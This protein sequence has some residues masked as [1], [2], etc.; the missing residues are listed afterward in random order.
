MKLQSLLEVISPLC[1]VGSTDKEIHAIHFD[2]RKIEDGDLFVAQAGTAVDGH[3]FIAQCAEKGAAAIVLSNRE[4]MPKVQ[5]D[6]VQSTKELT[7]ILVEDTDR[8]LGLLADCWFGSPSGKLTLVGVTGTNGKTT[9]ATLLY[10]LVR[11]LG[12]K[13]GLLST[14][15]NYVEEE[16]VPATHTT[17][18]ALELNALLARMVSVGCE[19]AFMEVSSHAIAQQR[20]AGLQFDGGLFTNLTR[21]H[22]DYHKTFDNYRDTKKRFFDELPKTAFAVTNIDDKNGTVMTQNTRAHVT[23]YSVRSLA[24]Y[25]AQILEEGFDGMLLQVNGQEVFVPLVGRFNVSNLL[26]IYGAALSLGFDKTEV[27]RVLSTLTPVNGRFETIHSTKGWTAIVDYAHTPDAVDNVIQTIREIKKE[28]AKLITVVGC[29]GNRDK[30]KRPMMAQIAKRGSEQLILTSD[31]P[32]DEEP[33]DILRDMT[34]GL[35]EEELRSTLVI[36]DRA[37]AIQTA[38]TLAQK[39]D[40]ILVAGKGHEDYQ[41]I[42]GVKHHFDDH[43]QVRK[44][45]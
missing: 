27:L 43:E 25:R 38:C 21:D 44:Y 39:D 10:K 41:I 33:K 12:H 16:A 1:V 40:V 29:G 13:A 18:D 35:T 17:P 5:S 32:R 30:G 7:Y 24:D 45:V 34:D 20:I 26:C 14:V 37:A 4:Y 3:Q 19:Y 36:E 42:R 2:S 31:N 9:I 11:A 15:C 6:K 23:T 8:A 28:G 22:I